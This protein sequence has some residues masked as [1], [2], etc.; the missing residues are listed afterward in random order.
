MKKMAVLFIIA[1]V[2]L[3]PGCK[4]EESSPQQKDGSAM[5]VERERFYRETQ[6]RLDDLNRQIAELKQQGKEVSRDQQS[7]YQIEIDRLQKKE[8]DLRENL[9]QIKTAG[10][11]AWADLK[12]RLKSALDDLTQGLGNAISEF[13]FSKPK[14]RW[15]E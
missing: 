1:A 7:H 3:C 5:D 8:I 4:K 11:E 14:P 6:A 13:K 15:S 10:K 9:E 12:P 2:F